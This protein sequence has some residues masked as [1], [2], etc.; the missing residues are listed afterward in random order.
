MSF[1]SCLFVC[2]INTAKLRIIIQKKTK[3][4]N[5]EALSQGVSNLYNR[6]AYSGISQEEYLIG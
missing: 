4:K 6:Y 5:K 3:I 2:K 1:F